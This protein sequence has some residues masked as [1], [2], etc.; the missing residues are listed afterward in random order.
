MIRFLKHGE[1]EAEKWDQCISMAH[2][3]NIYAYSWYLNMVCPAWCALVENNYEKVMPLPAWRKSGINYLAQPY[4]SQQLGIYSM[5]EANTGKVE[6]FLKE[7]PSFFKYIDINLNSSN[8]MTGSSFKVANQANYE[9]NLA[10]P[11]E[12]LEKGFSENL[13]RNL[14]RSK[15]NALT[16]L[17]DAD[18]EDIISLFRRFRGKDLHHLAGNQYD[19]LL[20]L[21]KQMIGM[22]FCEV[23]GAYDDQKQLHAGVIWAE[24]HQKS[25]FLFSAVS[26]QGRKLSAMP[27]LIDAYIRKHAGD[28]VILDFEGS[29]DPNLGRFYASFGSRLVIYPRI[30][31]NSL[32]YLLR[33]L[34]ESLR[35]IRSV[36]KNN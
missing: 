19:L 27:A 34:V 32:P 18:P 20:R 24:S 26:D 2:N 25:V 21:V 1:I 13:K 23:W 9:L 4:F 7:I 3:G 11:Y 14:K 8:S 15:D 35:S 16:I 12:E 29:N 6:E 31:R 10:R 28:K 22:G 36:I 17:Q 33:K 5:Q 30:V